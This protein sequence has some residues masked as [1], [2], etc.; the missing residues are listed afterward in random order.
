MTCATL[1]PALLHGHAVV[2]GMGHGSL[3]PGSCESIS[4]APVSTPSA[5]A[6]P[7]VP[8]VRAVGFFLASDPDVSEGWECD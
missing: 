4:L 5:G 2:I 7:T 6:L 1:S 3:E 8:G